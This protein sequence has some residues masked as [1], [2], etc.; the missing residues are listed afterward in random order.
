MSL[1]SLSD[2]VTDV[3]LF[4]QREARVKLVTENCALCQ[5]K[6]G[7]GCKETNMDA[8]QFKWSGGDDNV[9]DC[10]RFCFFVVVFKFLLVL[11][12]LINLHI[13]V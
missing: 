9:L 1:V 6:V 3:D 5:R 12:S 7:Q 2:G 11:L 4:L 13:F 8:G 10:L